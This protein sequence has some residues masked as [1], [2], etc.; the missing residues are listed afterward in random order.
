M[1]PTGPLPFARR[2]PG[3]LRGLPGR[4]GAPRQLLGR[5]SERRGVGV[6]ERRG[7]ERRGVGVWQRRGGERYGSLR[8]SASWTAE[9][10]SRPSRS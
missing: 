7:G 3:F 6:S 1:T 9:A 4:A 8:I 10:T 2:Q 5:R